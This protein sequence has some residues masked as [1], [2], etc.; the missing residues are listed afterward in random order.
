MGK[1]NLNGGN[2]FSRRRLLSIGGVLAALGLGGGFLY[3]HFSSTSPVKVESFLTQGDGSKK[4][5][6]VMTGSARKG[7]NSE[8]LASA[9]IDGAR[10]AGHTV[11]VFHSGITPVGACLNCDGCWIT[12]KPCVQ[13]DAFE[14]LSP[15]LEQ[16]EMLVFC[17]PLYWYNFSGH[18]K[19]AIDRMYPYSRKNRLR[20]MKVREAMLLMCG[21]SMFPRSFAAP[22]EAYRQ[23]L[24]YKR[25]EDRG[26]LFVTGVNEFGAMK[27]HRALGMARE[28]GLNV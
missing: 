12:G 27:N 18:L 20:D 6:L 28:M 5:V 15:L 10:E 16:A 19:C 23:M 3:R 22:A 21:E 11:N 14:A 1:G 9:F 13:D 2:R 17:S 24:G 7:G 4:N 26:R 8:V 25:W